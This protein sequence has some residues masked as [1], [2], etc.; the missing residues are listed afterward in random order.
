ME[1]ETNQKG[2][3]LL[4]ATASGLYKAIELHKMQADYFNELFNKL[5]AGNIERGGDLL[6]YTPMMKHYQAIAQWHA[7]CFL[8][9][10]KKLADLKEIAGKEFQNR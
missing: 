1:N 2:L 8:V 4:A 9:A 7:V 10:Q 6:E 5:S 3:M